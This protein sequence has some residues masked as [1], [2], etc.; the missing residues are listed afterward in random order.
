MSTTTRL[1]SVLQVA[2]SRLQSILKNWRFPRILLSIL[3]LGL[4]QGIIFAAIIPP[5][6][7][8]DEPGHFEYAWLVA[9]LPTW[10][11]AGQYDQTMRQ[12]MAISMANTRWY[13]VRGVKPDLSGSTPI[14]IGVTQTGKPPLYYFIASLPLR[15]L[16]QADINLQYY[17]A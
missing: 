14:P 4:V 17:A 7:N 2:R 6:W 11:K 3:L 10:P 16:H 5:W 15:V 13:Q 8:N 9:N 12:Q 1:G